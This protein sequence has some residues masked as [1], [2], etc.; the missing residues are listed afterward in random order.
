MRGVTNSF[1]QVTDLTYSPPAARLAFRPFIR[2]RLARKAAWACLVAMNPTTPALSSSNRPASLPR[3]IA[4]YLWRQWIRP[5][6]LPLLAVAAVKSAIAE[7]NIVPTGSM[8]PTIL[9]GDAV[10]VNKLAYDLRVPFTKARIA[11]WAD[12]A[13]GDVVVCF[14]PDDGQRLVKRVIGLPGDT[15]ELRNEILY[16]NGT[17]QNYSSLAATAFGVRDMEPTERAQAIFAREQLGRHSHGVMALP[18]YPAP[19]NYGP[20]TVPAASYLMMGD[21]RDNS[22]DSRYFG[23]MPRREIIGEL[24][25]VFASADPAHWLRPRFNRFFSKLD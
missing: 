16:V 1:G 3:R 10:F 17:R 19:R 7:I 22:R 9:E 11:R 12:P 23:F 21:N 13:R 6:T 5:M 8:K 24:T 4:R 14:A 15:I 20:I 25:G 2:K 18:A